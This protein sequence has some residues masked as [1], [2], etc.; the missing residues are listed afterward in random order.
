MDE[1][2]ERGELYL[3]NPDKGSTRCKVFF[4][5]DSNG[6][7][8]QT[9]WTDAGRMKGG[10]DYPTRK[11]ERLLERII[12]A[13]SERASIVFDC[14]MG[15]GTTQVVAMKLGR[16]FLGADINLGA[17]QTT[18]KRLLSHYKK[19]Q[20]EQPK[21]LGEQTC[22]TGFEVY[23][24]NHYE[25]FRNPLEAKDLLLDALEVNKL[26]QGGL[27]DGEKDGRMVK[28]MPINRIATRADLNA[29]ITG[30]DI[31]SLD[32]RQAEN[33]TK[34]V[35]KVTLICMGHEPDLAAQLKKE[36]LPYLLDVEVVDILRDKKNLTFKRD[37]E[38][39]I[40]RQNGT[41]IIECF[42]PMN[43]L[44]KLSLEMERVEDW[45]ELVESVM[46]DWNYGGGALEPRTVDI[47]EK[48][49]LVKG[50]YKVPD[51]AG[52]IRVKITDVL[53]ESLEVTLEHD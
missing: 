31:K 51:D 53:S 43:L 8:L 48:N 34:P 26:P 27:F 21:L 38:A 24:V 22:F 32:K 41:L 9:I 49:E 28:I 5:E 15:S 1:A 45:R 18:S 29:L 50:V 37:S 23:N 35:E 33:P 52:T 39:K 10:S 36:M 16:R 6:L 47:P 19:S 44:Q 20:M 2:L 40:T 7:L 14:F 4:L 30:F 12:K 11:P 3:R 13:S 17:V 42:Y 46:I 25:I